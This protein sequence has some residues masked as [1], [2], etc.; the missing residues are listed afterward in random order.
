MEREEE[1]EGLRKA[2]YIFHCG[3]IQLIVQSLLL[4][5]VSR[6]RCRRCCRCGMV[7]RFS[8]ELS[9]GRAAAFT[10]RLVAARTAGI[11]QS[12]IP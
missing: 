1:S 7:Y 12:L 3:S 9:L 11:I 5:L 2:S 8:D 4:L 6:W 10:L